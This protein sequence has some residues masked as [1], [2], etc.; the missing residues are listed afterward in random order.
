MINSHPGLG[1]VR[2]N[3]HHLPPVGH[4]YGQKSKKADDSCKTLIQEWSYSVPSPAPG[5]GIDYLNLNKDGI[6]KN[7]SASKEFR[8]LQKQ[9]PIYTREKNSVESFNLH[10]SQC[11]MD[12]ATPEWRENFRGFGKESLIGRLPIKGVIENKYGLD[13]EELARQADGNS[14]MMKKNIAEYERSLMQCRSTLSYDL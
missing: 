6:S 12:F 9:S 5:R 8:Q 2:T 7:L 14:R 4:Q 1:Q 10:K 3:Y 11:S 13:A